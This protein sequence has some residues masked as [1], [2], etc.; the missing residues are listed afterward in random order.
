MPAQLA[1]RM[2]SWRDACM[3]FCAGSRG[4]EPGVPERSEVRWEELRRRTVSPQRRML[5]RPPAPAAAAAPP[6][7][8]KRP[9]LAFGTR[10][11]RMDG[12][13]PGEIHWRL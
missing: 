6:R 9:H 13:V 10:L 2:R 11:P 5:P 12:S 3:G 1:Q 4:A 7:P 8:P